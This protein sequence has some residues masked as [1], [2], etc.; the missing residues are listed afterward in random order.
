[1]EIETLYEQAKPYIITN[2]SIV[3]V[4]CMNYTI[5]SIFVI[6]GYYNT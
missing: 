5:P 1:M 3:N 6:K 2:P 4:V